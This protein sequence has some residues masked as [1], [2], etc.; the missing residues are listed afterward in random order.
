MRAAVV[1][2]FGPP[3]V[4]RIRTDWPLPGSPGPGEVLIE[5]EAA[6]LNP[7]DL[8]NRAGGAPPDKLPYVAGREAAGRVLAIGE[9]I[10]DLAVGDDVFAFFGWFSRPGGHA[11]QVIIPAA[12]VSRRPPG[13]VIPLAAV[14]LAGLTAFQALRVLGAPAGATVAI[15]GGAGGVGCFAVQLAAAA[16]LRVLTTA[17]PDNHAFLRGL[18]AAEAVDYHDPD[19]PD[20]LEGVTHLLDLVGPAVVDAYQDRLAPDAR[21]V[22][23]VAVPDRLRPGLWAEHIRAEPGSVDLDQLADRLA[24]GTLRAVVAG[25]FPLDDI[26]AAHRLLEGGHV[27]GK[28]VIDLRA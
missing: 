24:S 4:V 3:E 8:K 21:I 13:P 2:E 11:E 9:D 12:M 5:V 7:S 16:G 26:V 6:G 22:S 17:S 10:D 1:G 23:V 27:R 15:T 25:T 14:P 19:A 28:L 20:A 18:G